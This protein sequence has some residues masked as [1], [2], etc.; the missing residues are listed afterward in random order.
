M[1]LM[2]DTRKP[3][4]LWKAAYAE[5]KL[6]TTRATFDTWMADSH[7]V[8]DEDGT[9]VIGV[10]NTYAR[11]WL[12]HRLKGLVQRTLRQ[13]SGREIG[14]RFVV[15]AKRTAKQQDYSKAGPLLANIKPKTNQNG[16][17]SG[18]KVSGDGLS[19]RYTFDNFVE[20]N[21]NRLAWAAAKTVAE[22]SGKAMNPLYIYGDVGMGKSHLLHAIGH[23]ARKRDLNVLCVTAETFTN[24]LVEAIRASNTA[25]LR[26]KYRTVD[27]LLLDDIQFVAGKESTQEEFFH[28]F[29]DLYDRDKQIV[30]TGNKSPANIDKLDARLRSRLEGGMAAELTS[31][32]LEARIEILRRKARSSKQAL[33]NTVLELIARRADSNVRQ[34]EGALT[35]VATRA[36]LTGTP[37]TLTM[38]ESTLSELVAKKNS[39]TLDQIL[40]AVAKVFRVDVESMRG[41]S[42]ARAVSM[43]RQVAMYMA[44]E[45]TKTSLPEI[46]KE[47]GGR[48][49]S[50]VL[51]SCKRVTDKLRSDRILRSQVTAVKKAIQ[52]QQTAATLVG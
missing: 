16:N 39:L 44:R 51:Y 11:D 17:G 47:L 33:P 22:K 5:L 13:V 24:D 19:E 27:V 1:H 3:T 23:Q 34:L 42:R 31:P 18:I 30:L 4:D 40:V 25:S 52:A 43:A 20:G 50:T 21:G 29:N 8:A 2:T 15:Q 26:D 49:H 48:T 35:R 6:Q 14:V 28:T 36:T 9:F 10:H 41:R 37:P 45:G 12:E 38:A 46:G 32:S 7:L